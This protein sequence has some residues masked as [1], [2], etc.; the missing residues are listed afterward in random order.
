MAK[1][2]RKNNFRITLTVLNSLLH[3][4]LEDDVYVDGESFELLLEIQRTLAVFEPTGDDEARMIWLE[5]PRGTAEEW[6]AFDDERSRC[7]NSKVDNLASYQ[8]ALDDE[9]PYEKE[10]FFLV[11]STYREN[12]FLKISDRNHRYVIFTNRHFREES[13]P[14]DMSWFMKSLLQLVKE[15]VDAIVKDPDAYNRYVEENLPFRQRSGRIRSKDLNRI[16]PE[17][18]LQV[19]NREYCIK[20]MKELIHREKAYE[21]G[22]GDWDRLGVPAPFDTMTIRTFCKYYRIA[23]T[24]CWS[25]SE[26]KVTNRACDVEDDVKYYTN[27]GMHGNLDEYDLDGE[28]DFKRF[29]TDHYGELGLSRMNVGATHY[30]ARGKWIITFGIS[31][32]AHDATGLRIALALYESGAPFVFYDA[33]NLLHILE[34]T[35][36]VRISPFTFHDYLQGGDDEG[37][38]DLPFVE[39]CDKEG[40]LTRKQYDKIVRLAKWEPDAQL[41]LDIKI[42]LEDAVYDLI[43]EEVKEPMTLSEIRHRIEKKYETYLSVFEEDGYTG[44]YYVHHSKDKQQSPVKSKSYYPTF[45]EAMRALLL[46]MGK[47]ERNKK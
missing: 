36:W 43:R 20:V 46:E 2:N 38:I 42:P 26:K 16:L 13:S 21:S 17:R 39:D 32:S 9:Y 29:A 15:R 4:T 11:T 35:G 45:N 14:T 33:E 22:K 30:Y 47:V 7:S 23:D 10:W 1:K 34:E 44:Y 18:R 8:E 12:T 6:K 37:V 19:E 31:Y 24:A 40:E 27:R 5:I 25:K 28:K 3:H 41:K